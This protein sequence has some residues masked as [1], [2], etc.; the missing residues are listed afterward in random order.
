MADFRR[1]GEAAPIALAAVLAVAPCLM[2]AFLRCDKDLEGLAALTRTVC[3]QS[4]PSSLS[5]SMPL[6]AVKAVCRVVTASTQGPVAGG[7][8][9][10]VADS[11]ADC[12][13]TSAA[14][15]TVL[16]AVVL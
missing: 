16:I 9:G 14:R 8:G 4:K 7:V 11:S 5:A 2:T 10:V 12:K 6:R 15:A 13:S 1:L 3:S